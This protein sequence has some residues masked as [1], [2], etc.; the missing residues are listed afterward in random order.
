[1]PYINFKE[2]K[3]KANKQLNNRKQNNNNITK[4]IIKDKG[5]LNMIPDEKWSFTTFKKKI[6]NN[7]ST[8]SEERFLEISYKIIACSIFEDCKLYNIKFKEC[9]F[10]G[11]KFIEC[12]FG[13]GGVIFENCNFYLENIINEPN[14]NKKDNLSCTFDKCSLYVKFTGTSL[15]YVIMEDCFLKESTFELTDITSGIIINSHLKKLDIIDS[16]LSGIKILDTYIEDLEF[17]DKLNTK[18]DEKSFIDKIKP[19]KN[20]KTEYEGI[21]M[22]YETIADKFEQ[23]SLRNNFGEYYYLCKTMQRKSLNKIGPRFGSWI[24]WAV[25]GYGERVVHTLIS[26]IIIMNIF[27]ILYLL[28]GLDIQGFKV[29]YLFKEGFPGTIKEFIMQY[30]ESLNLSVGTFAGVGTNNCSQTPITYMIANVEIIMGAA[31]MGIGIGTVTR[32]LIR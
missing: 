19:R 30:N 6:F 4:E 15:N 17:N 26:S 23:N 32:K 22:V 27:A 14:L 1:M 2:E 10:I 24:Y 28:L 18:L 25:S 8:Q 21:Y 31:M 16:D 9:T 29:A 11:C 5:S 3:F 13:G 20:T 7:E 12:D